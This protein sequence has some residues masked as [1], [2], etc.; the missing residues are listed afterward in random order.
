MASEQRVRSQ[1]RRLIAAAPS[2]P[3]S[4][5]R[6]G[7]KK[8]REAA[9]RA[10]GG[11][12]GG[13]HRWGERCGGGRRLVQLPDLAEQRG[14]PRVLRPPRHQHLGVGMVKGA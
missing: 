8:R 13:S 12:E 4:L 10:E 9:A 6:W 3:P 5:V 1:S 14:Q 2:A 7:E 11:T